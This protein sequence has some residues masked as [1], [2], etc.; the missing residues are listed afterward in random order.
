MDFEIDNGVLRR[1]NGPGGDVVAPDGVTI[2]DDEAFRGDDSLTSITLPDGV[3][4]IGSWAFAECRSLTSITLPDS[5]TIIGNGAFSDCTSLTGIALPE[6][7]FIGDYVFHNCW[8]KSATPLQ[9]KDNNNHPPFTGGLQ[10]Y[11][12]GPY[13]TGVSASLTEHFADHSMEDYPTWACLCLSSNIEVPR[14]IILFNKKLKKKNA[15]GVLREILNRLHDMYNAEEE[16]PPEEVTV[17][18]AHFLL[19]YADRVQAQTAREA[20]EFLREQKANTALR[21]ISANADKKTQKILGLSDKSDAAP[22]NSPL[23]TLYAQKFTKIYNNKFLRS[24]GMEYFPFPDVRLRGSDEIA[25]PVI[26]K[27]ILA[28]YGQQSKNKQFCLLPEADEA[29]ALL[30]H[31]SLQDALQKIW[32][33]NN[34]EE[35]LDSYDYDV[36]E[37][38]SSYSAYSLRP[39]LHFYCRYAS[40]KQIAAL[41]AQAKK[42][43]DW[44]R[45]GQTGRTM[46]EMAYDALYLSDTREAMLYID[47]HGSL[48]NYAQMRGMDA[49]TLRDT[50]LSEFGLD[51]DGHKSYDLGGKT[52]T[53]MLNPDLTLGL[54]DETAGKTVKSIP[55]KGADPEKYEAAKKDFADIKK[56]VKKIAKARN[57][58][59]FDAFLKGATFNGKNWAKAY[60]TNPLLRQI[61]SLLVW[62]Q[63]GRTFTLSGREAVDADGAAV[64]LSDAEICVAHPMEMDAEAVAVWQKYFTSHTLKQP[65]AQVWEPIHKPEDIKSDRYQGITIPLK[66]IMGAGKHGMGVDFDYD[67]CDIDI[68]F[69]DCSVKYDVVEGDFRHNMD[70]NGAFTVTDFRFDR[71]TRQVNHIVALLDRWT[72]RGRILKDDISI[73]PMLDGCTLAQITDYLNLSTENNRTNCT[74]LLLDYKNARFPDFDPMAEFTLDDL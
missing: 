11:Y 46:E 55:K 7:T 61:G 45:F 50:V 44:Y 68:S 72:V 14:W 40:D 54:Y 8:V 65:F 2:I 62:Q 17:Y 34:D 4:T 60:F 63:D 41:M 57:D 26:L 33:S 20:L 71:Y 30:D 69:S 25:P 42:W 73:A 27:Y 47:K 32:D 6:G 64:E 48:S 66:F 39:F 5:V 13:M 16:K 53:A 49:Q 9:I 52:V 51:A 19:N 12:K 18:A 29:A 36:S 67:S 15:D 56:N 31:E 24:I 38:S 59:L 43:H 3:T 10:I 21:F 1:Y 35:V 28:A 70:P 22:Q 37:L 23:Q 58:F 74:A